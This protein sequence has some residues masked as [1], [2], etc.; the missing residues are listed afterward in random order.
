MN[1]QK[2][3]QIVRKEL[4]EA[5]PGR[6]DFNPS[7]EKVLLSAGGFEGS[8]KALAKA[9]ARGMKNA[10]TEHETP[11]TGYPSVDTGEYLHTTDWGSA[12]RQLEK[13]LYVTILQW[14]DISQGYPRESKRRKK[15]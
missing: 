10:E 14:L 4:T 5:K 8:L 15:R 12:A 2:L 11:Q 9:V 13:K 1:D 3:R 7:A 6:Y